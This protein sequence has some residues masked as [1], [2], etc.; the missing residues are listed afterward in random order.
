MKNNLDAIRRLTRWPFYLL[1]SSFHPVPGPFCLGYWAR[2][3]SVMFVGR[4]QI[5]ILWLG[6]VSRRM[7]AGR[8]LLNL[9]TSAP[10]TEEAKIDSF[11][12]M[13]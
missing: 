10:G 2:L 4:S 11:S 8:L 12:P 13:H 6:P 1:T 3:A 5:E 7:K 9:N